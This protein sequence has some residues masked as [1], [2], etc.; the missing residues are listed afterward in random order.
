MTARRASVTA[1]AAVVAVTVLLALLVVWSASIGPS[2]V[3]TGDG[4]TRVTRTQSSPSE[5]TASGTPRKS[6]IDR[7]FEQEHHSGW[8][9]YVGYVIL[10]SL[11]LAALYLLRKAL[12]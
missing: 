1:V 2:Q 6:D 12:L 3:F 9:R 8:L 5:P 11:G 4:P 10:V 7:A